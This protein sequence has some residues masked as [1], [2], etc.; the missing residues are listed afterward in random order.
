MRA[1]WDIFYYVCIA[2]V[3]AN[4]AFGWTV[5]LGTPIYYGRLSSSIS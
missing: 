2:I 3:L 5:L 1:D 4:M